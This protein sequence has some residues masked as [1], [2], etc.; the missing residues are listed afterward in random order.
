VPGGGP[1]AKEYGGCAKIGDTIGIIFEFKN[2]LAHLSF[3]K[4]STPLGVCFN[5]I[6]PGCYLP[7]ACLY[8][9]EV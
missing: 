9:G 6:P 4:N 5:N 3:L 8:Y 7:C 2:G 1:I